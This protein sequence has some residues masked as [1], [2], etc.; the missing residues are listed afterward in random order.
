MVGEVAAWASR[1]VMKPAISTTQ[2]FAV[3]CM[4]HSKQ[5]S[6]WQ[7]LLCNPRLDEE[8]HWKSAAGILLGLKIRGQPMSGLKLRDH[9][10]LPFTVEKSPPVDSRCSRRS[11]SKMHRKRPE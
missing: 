10:A 6:G 7:G 3:R 11:S 4:C 5:S 1:I 8:P 2:D 9:S